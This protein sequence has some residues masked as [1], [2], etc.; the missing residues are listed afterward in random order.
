[1]AR[2]RAHTYENRLVCR[3]A[4]VSP[5]ARDWKERKFLRALQAFISHD[6]HGILR[7]RRRTILSYRRTCR[8]GDKRQIPTAGNE[9][10]KRRGGAAKEGHT[11]R[12]TTRG[13]ATWVFMRWGKKE[14]CVVCRLSSSYY[15][16][17]GIPATRFLPVDS[18]IRY[19][20]GDGRKKNSCRIKKRD[21]YCDIDRMLR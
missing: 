9:L 19:L 11:T 10:P 16:S 12:R 13:R 15:I 21:Y 2:A 17:L 8:R 14:D 18:T 20:N 4:G 3:R 1:M 6:F 7:G 5:F